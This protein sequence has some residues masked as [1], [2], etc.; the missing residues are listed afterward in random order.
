VHLP[1]FRRKLIDVVTELTKQR[2]RGT[3]IIAA[4]RDLC[5]LHHLTELRIVLVGGGKKHAVER[6]ID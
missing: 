3:G 5:G 1:V 6:E 2:D 4:E